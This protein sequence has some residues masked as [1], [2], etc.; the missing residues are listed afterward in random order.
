M[1][2]QRKRGIL[3]LIESLAAVQ[4]VPVPYVPPRRGSILSM[5]RHRSHR[6]GSSRLG[7]RVCLALALALAAPV[8]GLSIGTVGLA[9]RAAAHRAAH[10]TMCSAGEVPSRLPKVAS[11]TAR[12]LGLF[13]WA[14]GRWAA[15]RA[16]EESLIRPEIPHRVYQRRL[17]RYA[18]AYEPR[19]S[20]LLA[21]RRRVCTAWSSCTQRRVATSSS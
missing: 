12:E 5:E 20:R 2:P 19:R 18:F 9:R 10:C 11:A 14:H 1:A 17:G 16:E 13:S 6:D 21:S 15:L 8:S 3:Q 4:A 7:I